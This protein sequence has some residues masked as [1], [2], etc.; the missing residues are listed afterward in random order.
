MGAA[1]DAVNHFYTA[2]AAGDL[3]KADEVYATDCAFRLPPGPM[4]KAGH[5]QMGAAFL[6]GLPDAHMTIEHVVD[7]GDEVFVEGYFAGTHTG[8]LVGPAGTVPASGNTIELP[9]AD[10]FRVADG[11]IVEHRSYW[12]QV[13]MMRQLGAL[14][15]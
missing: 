11:L 9:Y 3:D 10:Y 4:D 5:K 13:E 15:G 12:D 14:P 7:G 1:L 6:A 2:F 8:D